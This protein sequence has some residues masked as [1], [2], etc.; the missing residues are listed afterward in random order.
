MTDEIDDVISDETIEA[1]RKLA[2]DEGN[3]RVVELCNEALAPRLQLTDEEYKR[4]CRE[5]RRQCAVEWATYS[6]AR[7]IIVEPLP[8]ISD[9]QIKRLCRIAERE[10]DGVLV[11]VC[12]RALRRTEARR[13]C[14]VAWRARKLTPA[15]IAFGL[16]LVLLIGLGA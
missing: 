7:G 13:A 4:W 1:L 10:G 2:I 11:S 15:L 5:V 8:T 16:A 14:E 12:N 3:V 6:A 9:D